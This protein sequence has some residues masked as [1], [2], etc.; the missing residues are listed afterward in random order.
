MGPLVIQ[1][2]R[3]EQLGYQEQPSLACTTQ[4]PQG[5]PAPDRLLGC[6]RVKGASGR[7]LH[8]GEAQKGKRRKQVR[9]PSVHRT[10]Y[11]TVTLYPGKIPGCPLNPNSKQ[12]EPGSPS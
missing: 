8:G 3:G 4:L 5:P 11:P 1:T 7:T 9:I 12:V 10:K 6:F 2:V